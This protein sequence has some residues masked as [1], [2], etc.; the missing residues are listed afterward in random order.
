MQ[1]RLTPLEVETLDAATDGWPCAVCG[2]LVDPTR[3]LLIRARPGKPA[4][5]WHPA[6]PPANDVD[7]Q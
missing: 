5:V 3:S 2:R 7:A 1:S 4:K 6:C